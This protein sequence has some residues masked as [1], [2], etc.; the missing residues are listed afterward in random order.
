M[1]KTGIFC[2]VP[3]LFV[4]TVMFVLVGCT[5]MFPVAIAPTPSFTE[6]LSEATPRY[7]HYVSYSTTYNTHL[8]FD[9]PSNWLF[10]EERIQYTDIL[11][12]GL[13]ERSALNVPTR[14]PD[15]QQGIPVDFGSIRID[16][17]PTTQG[18]TLESIVNEQKQLDIS[19]H[20]VTPLQ[21]YGFE[22]DEY[23]AY[24]LETLNDIPELY[25]SVMFNQ[26][27]LFIAYGQLFRIDFLI[28][29]KN[30]GSEFETGYEYFLNSLQIVP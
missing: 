11:Y 15:E 19:S 10:Y 23:N 14:A 12:I 2:L 7:L 6:N 1:N 8:E 24:V 30:R 13:T 4:V 25:T 18:Q 9:Y 21:D 22:I 17:Q 3:V 26:R 27:V 20:F 29:E 5:D 16:I 28:A